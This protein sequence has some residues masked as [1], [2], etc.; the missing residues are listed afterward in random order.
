[1]Q[2][3]NSDL[4]DIPKIFE[5]YRIAT[6]YMKSKKQVA[7]PEFQQQLI[8]E[9]IKEKRQWKIIIDDEIAC[10]WATT[11][12]DELIWGEENKIPS[13]YIHRI[14]T[15]PAFRGQNL[16]GNIVE[17]ANEYCVKNKF[18][19]VRL[20]TVGYNEGLIKHYFT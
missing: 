15:N 16:V 19:F 2:I 12:N 18:K 3:R 8:C 14:A 13:L 7:W 5:L 20:D 17:W 4:K 10:I 1:M 11:R 9:E 6:E